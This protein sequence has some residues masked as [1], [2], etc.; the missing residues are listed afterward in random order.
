MQ[1]P[2]SITQQVKGLDR[3]V[4]FT[5]Y[6]TL[7][8]SLCF[9]SFKVATL[10][11]CPDF[12]IETKGNVAHPNT[13]NTYFVGETI[14]FTAQNINKPIEWHLGINNEIR[15]G[16]TIT[17]TYAQAGKYTV[18][19]RLENGCEQVLAL[20][21]VPYTIN[22][23]ITATVDANFNAILGNDNVAAGE[24]TYFNSAL[25]ANHY[26]WE[27]ENQPAYGIKNDATVGYSIA[28]P[29]Q[30][31]IKLTLDN[32]GKKVYKKSIMVNAPLAVS[33]SDKNEIPIPAPVDITPSKNTDDGNE[34]HSNTSDQAT[35]QSVI[36]PDAEIV[37]L[38]NLIRDKKKTIV[39]F[40]N[41]VC[42]G[43]DTKVMGNDKVMTLGALVEILQ[44]KK[45]ALGKKP[46]VTE[47]KAVRD[48]S[49]GNCINILYVTYK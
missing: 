20:N 43:A 8:A 1:M 29:G 11:T 39:E 45:W 28:Q 34:E 49:N 23:N 22:D 40:N 17:F 38:L 6:I 3:K 13:R 2:S 27:I 25:Q 36:I 33:T 14:T 9:F 48:A 15:K 30:Y 16:N 44:E 18:K 26:Q 35:K 5:F 42:K 10:D 37:S 32:D 24:I 31:T 7:I 4:W 47:V 21:I 19:A 41:M 12:L 46:K